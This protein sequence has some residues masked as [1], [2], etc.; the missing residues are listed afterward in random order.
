MT[1]FLFILFL[2]GA[3]SMP[4][5]AK[6][7]EEPRYTIVAKEGAYEIR[8]YAPMLIAEVTTTGERSDAANAGFRLLADFI[9]GNNT[10]QTKMAMTTPVMQQANSE[11]IATTAPVLQQE[12]ANGTWV[13]RFV[14]PQNYTTKTLPSPKNNAVRIIPQEGQRFAAIRFTGWSTVNNLK[15][16]RLELEKWMKMQGLK[17][18]AAPVYAFYN[19]PWTLPFLRRNEVLIAV[20]ATK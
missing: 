17:A 5:F 1:R 18:L 6:T 10:A 15:T 7:Y 16:H 3:T 13:V 2:I 8:D 11:K 9:F 19:P 14:M 4:S 12:E 20:A